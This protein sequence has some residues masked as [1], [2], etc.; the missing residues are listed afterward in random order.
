MLAVLAD[1]DP[2]WVEDFLHPEQP[3]EYGKLKAEF[4]Q[5]RFAAGEQQ[6]TFWD[7]ERLIGEGQIDVLQPD[8]SRCGGLTV[9]TEVARRAHSRGREIV[10]HSWL[11]DLLH[12]YSLHFL[13]TLEEAH[14]VEFN[15]AQSRL[16]R[17][18]VT[19]HLTL[20]ADGTV[21][22][23]TGPGLGVHV[24]ESFVRRAQADRAIA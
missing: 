2:Y 10:T 16:S 1:F 13:A 9:A 7:F 5:L 8:L 18:V 23:P 22:V 17:G 19:D 24:D 12:A 21:A 4:P 11:T 6:A 14:W 20:D 3:V 15:V